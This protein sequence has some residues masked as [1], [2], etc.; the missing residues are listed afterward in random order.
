MVLVMVHVTPL[1]SGAQR[2]MPLIECEQ[3]TTVAE[4]KAKARQAA[5]RWRRTQPASPRASPPQVAAGVPG[6][7]AP[8]AQEL[9]FA[10]E[11][12]E[13]ARQLKHYGVCENWLVQARAQ[14]RDR[15][16]AH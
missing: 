15:P 5:Q 16:R 7:P 9:V 6:A 13:D 4:L 14:A 2:C 8:E 3:D 10:G 11:R 12:C 1:D